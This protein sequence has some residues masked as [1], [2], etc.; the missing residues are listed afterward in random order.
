MSQEG[1]ALNFRASELSPSI[2]QTQIRKTIGKLLTRPPE[3]DILPPQ[4][5]HQVYLVLFRFLLASFLRLEI[6]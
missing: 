1:G 4:T 6:S 2:T 5:S 3:L